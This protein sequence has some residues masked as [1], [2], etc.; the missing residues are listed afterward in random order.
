[1]CGVIGV[2]LKGSTEADLELVRRV[3]LE[4]GIRGL[5]ATGVTYLKQGKLTTIKE[6]LPAHK[7]LEKHSVSDWCDGED[8]TMIAHCRYST[9]DIEFNQPF[10]N[11]KVSIVHNGVISQELP[12]NWEKLYGYKTETKNDSELLLKTIEADK[13]PFTEWRNSSISAI[14]LYDS[15]IMRFYRNGKRP[16]C[17]TSIHSGS[18]ITSTVDVLNRAGVS[19]PV[20]SVPPGVFCTLDQYDGFVVERVVEVDDLQD[21]YY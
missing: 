16:M 11:E 1:M 5:H 6:P 21:C 4:S 8:L 3:I 10:S 15:N 17:L 2:K 13:N 14:E 7:F 19:T 12:E 18:I 9:S 20:E